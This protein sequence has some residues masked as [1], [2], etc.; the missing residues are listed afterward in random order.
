LPPVN[1]LPSIDP[2]KA[3]LAIS[4]DSRGKVT[5]S[6]SM[7][8]PDG[9]KVEMLVHPGSGVS[10][11]LRRHDGMA[12][13]LAYARN[14]MVRVTLSD[15]RGNSVAVDRE[16]MELEIGGNRVHVGVDRSGR[17]VSVDGVLA[18][19]GGTLIA[20]GK[21]ASGGTLAAS[22]PAPNGG[23]VQLGFDSNGRPSISGV[24]TTDR[25]TTITLETGDQGRV[26]MS[27]SSP[28]ME[29]TRG[30]LPR[31]S[32]LSFSATAEVGGGEP[33]AGSVAAH[34]M[35]PNGATFKG[36][37][38]VEPDGSFTGEVAVEWLL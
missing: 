27:A 21:N 22:I 1:S 37:A 16:G 18:G 6:A 17:P 34:A 9:G 14:G 31:G 19:P 8:T 7:T 13:N 23:M 4:T 33:F 5:G 20:F 29:V 30:L 26:V 2:P 12:A 3:D 24:V 11:T 32:R 25:G 35:L 10:V 15:P 28:N 38:A 36:L